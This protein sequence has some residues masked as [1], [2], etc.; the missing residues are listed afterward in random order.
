MNITNSFI[1]KVRQIEQEET[2]PF[3][4][5]YASSPLLCEAF[6]LTPRTLLENIITMPVRI[7]PDDEQ[8]DAGAAQWCREQ[9]GE[10]E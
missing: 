4:Q 10:T 9:L 3:R 7:H 8:R 5:G 1:E 6:G 2:D